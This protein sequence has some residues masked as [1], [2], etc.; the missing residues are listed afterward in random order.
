M[1]ESALTGHQGPRGGIEIQRYSIVL[2]ILDLGARRRW[3]VS[4]TP[5]PL[6]PR[7]KPGTQCTGGWV[8]LRAG[9][10]VCEK[11]RPH[12]VSIPGPSSR[13]Q[14][15]Y[16]LSYRAHTYIIYNSYN[17]PAKK[18]CLL[19]NIHVWLHEQGKLEVKVDL[20]PVMK[21]HRWIRGIALLFL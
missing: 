20:E 21:A 9:L 2:L 16:R 15:L 8:S 13:S 6:Y 11:S 5:R 17:S 4:T 12:R 7:E 19:Y 18:S 10:N 3:V 14:S 1:C